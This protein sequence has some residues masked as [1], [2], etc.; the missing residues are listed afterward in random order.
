M[1]RNDPFSLWIETALAMNAA[2][3]TIGVRM[4]KLQQAMLSGDLSGGPEATRMVIE[5][6]VAAQTGAIRLG[7]GAMS[8][9]L[10]PLR[11]VRSW[12]TRTRAAI[13]EG[14]RPGF[15]R[16]RANARRLTRVR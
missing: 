11:T 3:L 6:I 4:L 16:A 9:A 14:A 2:A 7:L 1:A 10:A 5:K 15:R 8:M 13:A 12:G